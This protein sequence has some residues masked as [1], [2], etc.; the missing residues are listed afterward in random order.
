MNISV[1]TDN[2]GVFAT[3]LENEYA[4]LAR[5]LE[6]ESTPEGTPRYQKEFIYQ[7]LENLR[8]MGLEQ[9]FGGSIPGR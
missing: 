8:I 5:D 7:W 2:N 9:G 3:R 1:N 4:L 6:E